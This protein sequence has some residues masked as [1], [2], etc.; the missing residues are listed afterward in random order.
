[1]SNV[2][3]NNSAFM[4]WG[5][6]L[7]QHGDPEAHGGHHERYEKHLPPASEYVGEESSHAPHVQILVGLVEEGAQQSSERTNEGKNRQLED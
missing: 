4:W 2:H 7:H 5:Y 3:A 6:S 1:M